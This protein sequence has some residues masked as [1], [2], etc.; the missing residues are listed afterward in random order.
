MCQFT[1]ASKIKLLLPCI[2]SFIG[3]SVILNLYRKIEEN[4][5]GV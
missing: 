1:K 3:I 5:P 2:Y 4:K